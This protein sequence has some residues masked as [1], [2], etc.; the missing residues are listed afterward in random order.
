MATRGRP[1][2]PTAIKIL[3]GTFREDRHG[4]EPNVDALKK[5]PNPPSSLGK[6]GKSRWK[7]EGA[8]MMD[9]GILAETDLPAL[10]VYCSAWDEVRHCEKVLAEQ[11]EYFFRDNGTMSAHPAIRRKGEAQDRIRAYQRE[12]GM[13]PSS[14][15]GVKVEKRADQPAVIARKRG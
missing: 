3:D 5:L 13:T 11:G 14:R 12:F 2:K 10:E 7:I 9:K 6:E 1:R 15:T 8:K 4:S